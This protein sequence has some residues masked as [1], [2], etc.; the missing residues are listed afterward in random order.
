[1]RLT[2]DR[3]LQLIRT[4]PESDEREQMAVE[5]RGLRKEIGRLRSAIKAHRDYW[6]ERTANPYDDALHAALDE[7]YKRFP[8]ATLAGPPGEG[9]ES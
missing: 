8:P 1:M 9:G 4:L 6:E 5:L 3:L 7:S 2:D